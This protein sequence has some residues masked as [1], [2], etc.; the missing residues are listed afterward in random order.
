MSEMEYPA[1]REYL[2]QVRRAK[3]RVERLR[4]RMT[5]LR[6][7]LTDTAVHPANVPR[8]GSGDLQ[9]HETIQAEIDELERE[10]ATAEKRERE[11]REEVGITICRLEDP[12]V[13]RVMILRYLDGECWKDVAQKTNYGLSQTFRFN[14]IGLSELEKLLVKGY[15][16]KMVVD[17]S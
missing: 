17:G 16:K 5:N 15:S 2:N 11:I 7:L 10:I 3:R 13:Q 12:M 1:A 9:K 4:W 14:E 8:T 6:M